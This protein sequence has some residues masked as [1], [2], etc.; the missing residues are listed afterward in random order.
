MNGDRYQL[1]WWWP[2]WQ[3]FWFYRFEGY[4]TAIY[5]W[6]IT[7]GFFEIRRWAKRSGE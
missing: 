4:W 5:S 3:G 2:E 7:I 6:S 1:V